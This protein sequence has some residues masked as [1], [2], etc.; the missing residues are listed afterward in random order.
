M[1]MILI[2]MLAASS[3]FGTMSLGYAGTYQGDGTYQ[4]SPSAA[5]TRV[6]ASYPG[7]GDALISAL[8]ELLLA[9]PSLADDVAYVG[10]RSGEVLKSA[11]ADALAQALIVLT[12]RGNTFGAGRIVNAAQL[13]GD[14]VMQTAVSSAVATAVGSN[15]YPG[16]NPSTQANCAPP[17]SPSRPTTNCQ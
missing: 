17:V 7:G 5:V 13:S 1:R 11:A 16:A 8:R 3:L 9:D 6:F 12:S 15:F 10:A 14:S 2:V 4:G